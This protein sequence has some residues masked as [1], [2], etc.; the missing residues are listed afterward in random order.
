MIDKYDR[1]ALRELERWKNRMRKSPSIINRASKGVQKKLNS[2]L[3][4]KYHEIVTLAIK[5]MVK[6]VLTGSKYITKKSYPPMSLEKREKLVREKLKFYRNTAMIEGIGTGAGGILMA[7]ADFPLLLTIKI[8]FLYDIA[9]IYGF[10]ITD[11]RERLY[12]L[13]IFQLA[14]SS[15]EKGNRVFSNMEN[16]EE[17]S[18]N[19]PEDLNVEEWRE[20]QQEYRDYLDLAKLLQMLPGVGA[21]VGGYTNSKLLN[22]LGETAMNAYRMRLM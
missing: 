6:I 9:T 1:Y 21:V 7:L 11:Y 5:N 14:F 22:K 18:K 20:F 17:Y 19:L 15:Q 8:K 10:D 4:E 13:N 3:P 16:W 12:I 2:I